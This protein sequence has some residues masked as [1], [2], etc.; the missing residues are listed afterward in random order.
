MPSFDVVSEIDMPE[1]KNAVDQ[2]SREISTR[3]DFKGTESSVILNEKD[4]TIVLRSSTPDRLRAVDTVLQE[5]LVKRNVSL[6]ALE[7]GPIE[8]AAKG[9]ARQTISLVSGLSQDRAR[10]ITTTIKQTFPKAAQA[11]IQGEQV[12]VTA[13]KRDDLQAVIA[14]LKETI[15]DFPLQFTNFRD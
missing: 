8:D 12:R 2:A 15:T 10:K 13:K 14:H 7:N 1:V 5:R 6:R 11:Q 9:S 3:F 4:R